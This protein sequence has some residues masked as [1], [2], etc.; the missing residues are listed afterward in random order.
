MRCKKKRRGGRREGEARATTIGGEAPDRE[1]KTR[2]V[3]KESLCYSTNVI[4]DLV[5]M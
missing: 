4:F 5:P 1:A 3:N 2:F